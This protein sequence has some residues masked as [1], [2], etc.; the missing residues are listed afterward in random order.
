MVNEKVK[1]DH[2]PEKFRQLAR[3]EHKKNLK[4]TV[5]FKREL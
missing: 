1:I 4:L 3:D 5:E 2:V